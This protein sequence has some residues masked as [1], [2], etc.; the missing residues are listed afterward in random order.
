VVIDIPASVIQNFEEIIN[1]EEVK[2][3]LFE[4]IHNSYVGGNVYYDGD[5]FTYV[6]ESG[7][8]HV[9]NFEEIVK[10]NET[11][12]TLVE[13]SDGKYTYTSENNTVTVID[14]P[15]SVV[16]NFETIVNSGPVEVNGDTFTTIEEYIEHIANTSVNVGGSDFITVT[17]TGTSDDPYVVSIKE[18]DANSMLI[19]NE[20]GE[21]EWA[22]IESIV[23]DNE[24][25]TTLVEGSDGK[26]TYT[27]ENNTVT[28]IDIPASVV[29]NFETIVNSGPVEVNGDTFTTIEEY[30]EHI[31]NSSVTIGGSDFITVTGTGTSDD[32]YVVSIKEGDANSM[33]ITNEAGELEWATIES[34]IQANQ[35]N[36]EVAPGAGIAVTDATVD[37]TTTYTVAVKAESGLEIHD[38]KVKLGGD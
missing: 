2:N 34:I 26:Y 14:I 19:T 7:D 16:Q 10:D 24:T 3:E 28:V 6:D 4:T 20:A 5:T 23:K 17:G 18:G 38:D 27:S 30:I 25:V 32:P 15:A 29:Q 21:L 33:L 31:A 36:T 22:T 12:T 1:N 35:K 13:G 11:V 9:I 37:N 8:S